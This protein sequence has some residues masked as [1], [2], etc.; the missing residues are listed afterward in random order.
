M[1]HIGKFELS[2]IPPARR[3]V[4]QIEVSFDIDSNG[5]L[6]VTA[7]DK[8]TGKKQD[9]KI[10][11]DHNRLSKD[12]IDRMVEEAERF[13]QDDE[14]IRSKLESKSKLENYCYQLKDT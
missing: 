8:T 13:K 4:P 6:C 1:G 5:I 14:K 7:E 12:D 10:T 11:N 3:G 9:I 2:G